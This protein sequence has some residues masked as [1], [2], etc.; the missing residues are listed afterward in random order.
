MSNNNSVACKIYDQI[1][2]HA[3]VMWGAKNTCASSDKSLTFQV[4]GSKKFS[5]VKVTLD[6][7]DEYAISFYKFRGASCVAT[8]DLTGIQCEMLTDVIAAFL[9]LAARL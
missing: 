2:H 9:E 4:R 7:N 1:G 3:F 6:A 8:K 5:H